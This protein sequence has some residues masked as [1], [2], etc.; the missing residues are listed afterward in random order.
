M[1]GVRKET[2][3]HLERMVGSTSSMEGAHR[4]QTVCEPGSSMDFSN[5]LAAD[6]V[7]RSQSSITTTRKGEIDAPH[8]PRATNS[9]MSSTFIEIPS[10]AK[11][12]ISGWLPSLAV[13]QSVQSPQPPLGH[14]SEVA[15]AIARFD[16]P[17]PG[18]PTK[19]QE[20]V[21]S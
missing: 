15:K 11:I 2:K 7:M 3:R 5:A 4:S 21:I 19:S 16:L 14:M 1:V 20:W 13:V 10:V 18:E 8:E 17:E 9:R 12:S 6:S